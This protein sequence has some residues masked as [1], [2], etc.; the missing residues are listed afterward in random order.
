VSSND[1]APRPDSPS[2]WEFRKG[3]NARR[4]DVLSALAKLLRAARDRTV[5]S[6]TQGEETGI[7]AKSQR[8][9]K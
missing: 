1:P 3:Q 4:G 8:E 6:D 2:R 5:T 9:Q 7:S